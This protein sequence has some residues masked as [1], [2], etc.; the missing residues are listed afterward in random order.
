MVACYA[1]WDTHQVY[2]AASVSTFKEYKPTAENS[3][4]FEEL[5]AINSDVIGWLTIYDTSIDYPVLQSPKTDSDYLSKNALGEWE[6]SGSLFLDHFNKSDFSDFN[7][8]I[9]GHHMAGPT[10]F[11][12]LDAFLDKDFF[13]K[14]EYANLYYSDTGLQLVQPTSSNPNMNPTAG[15]TY[16]FVKFSG[17][18]HGLQIFAMLQADG[19]DT[20]IYAVPSTTSNQKEETLETIAE[21]ALVVRNLNT[22]E[23]KQ[24]GKASA[25]SPV[26]TGSVDASYFGITENDRIVLMSTCSADLTN[27]RFV[28]CAK[29]LDH[30]VENPFPEEDTEPQFSI[31][32]FSILDNY[33]DR[34]VWQWILFLIILI[35]VTWLL[36]RAE[37]YRVKKSR[38]RKAKKAQNA[39]DK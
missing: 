25:G 28:L 19:Y 6:G 20:G 26:K 23:T 14:H 16:E 36:Y 17:K 10:M 7:T 18:N 4:S 27:G 35:I 12:E 33:L 5:R 15:L 22:G 38:E 34:P 9:Y 29:I 2:S 13:D 1:F 21:R 8:I 32:V 30:E 39:S 11:G 3:L 24:L 31:D 37:L